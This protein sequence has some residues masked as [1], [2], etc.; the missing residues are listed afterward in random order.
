[1]LNVRYFRRACGLAAMFLGL[2]GV[3]AA[4]APQSAAPL[5][6]T[7]ADITRMLAEYKADPKKSAEQLVILESKP[8]QTDSKRD[9][10]M[11]HL[12]LANAA[13]E[14]GALQRQTEHMQAV[15]DIG[16]T[17]DRGSEF[18]TLLALE[19]R[20]GNYQ[21]GLAT[22]QRFVDEFGGRLGPYIF[23]TAFLTGLGEFEQANETLRLAEQK[24]KEL[25]SSR[26]WG[27]WNKNWVFSI[28]ILRGVVLSAQ[29]KEAAAEVAV[30]TAIQASQE[31]EEINKLRLAKNIATLP[32]GLREYQT[33]FHLTTLARILVN[34]GR[35]T[36]AEQAAREA[37]TRSAARTGAGSVESVRLLPALAQVLAAQGRTQ[38]AATLV[39]ATLRNL[40]QQNIAPDSVAIIDLRRIRGDL[41]VADGRYPEALQEY[42][43]I[44]EAFAAYPEAIEKLAGGDIGWAIALFKAGKADEASTMLDRLVAKNR[45]WLGDK[46]I[47]TAELVGVQAMSLGTRGDKK[48]ALDA[49]R[50]ALPVLLNAAI[51]AGDESSPL[52]AQRLSLILDAYLALLAEIRATPLE[53]AAGIDAASEGFRIADALRGQKI[54]GAVA[55]SAL[56]SAANDPAIGAEIRKEQDLA[57]ESSALQRILR[58]LMNAPAEKQLSKTI[59][60]MKARIENIRQERTIIQAGIEKRFPAYANLIRPQPPSLAEAR[61][62][63][64]PNEAL[65]NIFSTDTATFLWAFKKDGPVAFAST[66]GN[67]GEL[68]KRVQGLRRALDLGDADLAKGIPDFDLD[69]AYRL[70]ADLLLPVAAGWQGATNLLVAANGALSQLPLALLPTQKVVVKADPKLPYTQYK[71]VPWL[72]RQA[73]FTQLPSVNALVSLRK[74]PVASAERAPFVGFGD[75]QFSETPIQVASSRGRLRNLS[76]SR[77]SLRDLEQGKSVEWM[78]YGKIPPLPDTRDEILALAQAL[79]ANT[80]ADVFLGSKASKENLKKLDLSKRRVVA[81]A[82]HGVL[83]GDFPGVSEPSLALANPGGGK[84]GLLTREE[85]LGLKLDADWVVLSACN[86][87]GGDGEGADALS[88]LGRGFFYAGSRALLVTHWPVESGS[89]KTL[90]TGIFERQAGDPKLSRAEA[91]R[92]SMLA[93]MQAKSPDNA[94]AYAHPMF[95]APYALVGEGGV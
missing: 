33:D 18:S 92:Q 20:I 41:M 47:D 50:S 19:I 66:K 73:A 70:Y 69:A 83:A 59:G 12:R 43:K 84:H 75:P 79:Q 23:K 53:T 71:D 15:I 95:W 45:Q 63:L 78:D 4:D 94:F 28:E 34:L 6:R 51:S 26:N 7:V 88:G 3:H 46:H 54:Q 77:P 90:V 60:D 80:E 10:A 61:A 76:I 35:F 49:F 93:L 40:E 22:S 21:R 72:I 36:E 8:P 25:Q 48:G 57:Q 13:G 9:L 62:V 67:R 68:T 29:G 58:D 89:A 2:T 82:T 16:G 74:L 81:F 39:T 55:A 30:R 85:I 52:R 65:I 44:R 87:A 14:L 24:F 42:Q 37:F 5:P 86:T 27:M 1:M 11:Y 32:Q 31:D 17:E 38:E 91:L 56:R 64:R